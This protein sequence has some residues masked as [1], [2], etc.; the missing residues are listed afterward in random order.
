MKLGTLLEGCNSSF[1]IIGAF[2]A[3]RY[4]SG[5]PSEPVSVLFFLLR[6]LLSRRSFTFCFFLSLPFFLAW[7]FMSLSHA[8]APANYLNPVPSTRS[9]PQ[10]PQCH[11]QNVPV[12]RRSPNAV[13][14]TQPHPHIT[15]V[16]CPARARI[17]K[18]TAR[19]AQ[20]TPQPKITTPLP[21]TSR[22]QGVFPR[23]TGPQAHLVR[24]HSN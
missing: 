23:A 10:P 18:R 15:L 20:Q 14:G 12:P 9:H 3:S 11:A 1:F 21:R 22:R 5:S 4:I 8:P 2:H 24:R 17:S 6:H 13:P 7:G 16:P 19:R